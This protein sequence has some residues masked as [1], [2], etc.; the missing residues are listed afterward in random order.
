MRTLT[1]GRLQG[2][3]I[4]TDALR[5]GLREMIS[6]RRAS[7]LAAPTFKAAIAPFVAELVAA[8]QTGATFG[9]LATFLASH[10][11]RH[12]GGK[13]V[14]PRTLEVYLRQHETSGQSAP[15][16]SR[17]RR[18]ASAAA[19]VQQPAASPALPLVVE[20]P[21]AVPEPA[22]LLSAPAPEAVRAPT[23]R[24]LAFDDPARPPVKPRHVSDFEDV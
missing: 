18:P 20:G 14:S 17:T 8:R 12:P 15:S 23:P 19:E 3:S 16:K 4:D 1:K 2:V 11:I 22:V 6:Q 5:S 7:P 10:G 21:A 13:P 9:D 24:K